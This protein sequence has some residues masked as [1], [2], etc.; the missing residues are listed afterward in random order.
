[1]SLMAPSFSKGIID[2]TDPF[3]YVLSP[4]YIALL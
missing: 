1:V 3:P 4:S 2:W